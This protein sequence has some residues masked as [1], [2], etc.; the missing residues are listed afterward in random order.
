MACTFV[1]AAVFAHLCAI[2][3][4]QEDG[5]DR[6]DAVVPVVGGFAEPLHALY[7]ARCLPAIAAR[8]ATGG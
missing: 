6:W 3:A 5:A 2:A 4:E 7:H 1:Q 8:L